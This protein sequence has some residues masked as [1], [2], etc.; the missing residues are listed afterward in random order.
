[1]GYGLRNFPEHIWKTLSIEHEL[2]ITFCCSLFFFS[3][4]TLFSIQ[5]LLNHR[6]CEMIKLSAYLLKNLITVDTILYITYT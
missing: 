1:M 4:S 5:I 2:R 3:C 6:V